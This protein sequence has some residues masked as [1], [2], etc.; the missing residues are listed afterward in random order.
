MN[1]VSPELEQ[2]PQ[3]PPQAILAQMS[4][5][6]IVSQ[7][8]SVASKLYIADYLKTDAKTIAELAELTATHEPSLYRLMRALTSVGVFQKDADGRYSNSPVSEL[9]R[10]DHPESFRSASH[11]IGDHEHWRAHGNMLQSVKTGEIAFEYTFGMPVFP[12][13]AQNAEPAKVFDNAMTDFSK[14]IA[15]A[16][17]AVYDFSQ[18]NT[19][20]DIGGGHGLLLETILKAAPDAKGILFDQPQ[21]V[22]GANVSERIEKVSGDFFSAI[23]VEA[24]LYLMKFIIHD[25]NDEQS[26]TILRNLAKSAK[27]GARV[28]L[29]ESVVEEDDSV[30]SMSKVMDLNMLA[31]TGGKERTATEYAELLEKTRF[32]LTRVIPTPSPVQIVEAVRV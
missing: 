13:Y 23:P 21:V 4:M 18:A 14:S 19:I 25:W 15:N 20:A 9:L 10:S 32:K 6:F 16:V 27:P 11:M 30:P 1:A 24:D 17:V 5:G 12:Y 31:M 26:E 3:M 8:I 29:I 2:T 7:A 28:L 22:A